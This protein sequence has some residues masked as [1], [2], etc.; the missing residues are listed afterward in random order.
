M[1]IRWDQADSLG[2]RFGDSTRWTARLYL[3][4]EGMTHKAEVCGSWLQEAA[5]KVSY[6]VIPNEVR[7]LSGF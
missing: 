2:N 3:L 4:L 1:M 5:E 6:F 7:N